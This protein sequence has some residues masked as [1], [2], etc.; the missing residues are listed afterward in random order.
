[1]NKFDEI[2]IENFYYFKNLFMLELNCLLLFY[3]FI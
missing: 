1:M 3:F 2:Y